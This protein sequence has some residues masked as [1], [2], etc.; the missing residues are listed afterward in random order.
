MRPCYIWIPPAASGPVFTVSRP[1]RTG[2][3][4][5]IAGNG[6]DAATVAPAA[7]ARNLRRSTLTAISLLLRDSVALGKA[8]HV[9]R[10]VIED[11]LLRDGRDLVEPHLA[12]QPLDVELL[13]VAVAAVRLHRDI[14]RLE[15]GFGRQ[16]LRGVGLRAARPAVIE[17]PRRLQADELRRLELRPRHGERMRDRLVL[18]D[19]SVEDHALLRVLHGALERGA[20]DADGLDGRHDALGIERVEQ[21]IEALPHFTDHVRLGDLQPIDEDLVGVD[22]GATE[23]LDLAHGDL[24]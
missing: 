10:Q 18:P 1:M 14:A 12:P 22:G 15:P 24:R 4:W 21:V 19:R 16:E 13:G 23:L 3:D 7:P 9:L 11:H 20:A 5:A 8:Q 2:F 6:K 17:Q